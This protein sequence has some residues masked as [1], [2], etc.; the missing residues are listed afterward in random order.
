MA[1]G[2]G[3][4]KEAIGMRQLGPAQQGQI[5]KQGG[6]PKMQEKGMAYE[7]MDIA[8]LCGWTCVKQAGAAAVHLCLGLGQVA[9]GRG[10]R[11]HTT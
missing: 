1:R 10:P 9:D 5:M 2:H 8:V 4:R 7:L 3:W 11:F 6:Q